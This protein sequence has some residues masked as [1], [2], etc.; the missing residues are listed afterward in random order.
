MI[1]AMV[2]DSRPR[3]CPAASMMN[4]RGSMS[5]FFGKYVR[6]T[7]LKLPNVIGCL[8][9]ATKRTTEQT[10]PEERDE[11][12]TLPNS[13]SQGEHSRELNYFGGRR[14]GGGIG[15]SSTA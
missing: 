1:V 6:M 5:P 11:T 3:T 12:V 2:V 13:G 9:S 14:G 15:T 10:F 4:Q 7:L 8:T